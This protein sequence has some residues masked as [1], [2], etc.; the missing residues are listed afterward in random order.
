M[1]YA[2]SDKERASFVFKE[3]YGAGAR[4]PSA[5]LVAV[6]KG[7][8]IQ[9]RA[10]GLLSTIAFHASKE[11]GRKPVELVGR[12]IA[13]RFPVEFEKPAQLIEYLVRLDVQTYLGVQ[14]EVLAFL[15]QAKLITSAMAKVG[16]GGWGG[17]AS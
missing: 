6:L 5:E 15:G 8:P 1:A 4:P 9:V 17:Q 16:N 10:Q 13:A 3:L 12:W 2:S 14:A 11:T 7:L